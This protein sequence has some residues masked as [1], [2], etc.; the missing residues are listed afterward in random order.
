LNGRCAA[1]NFV[2]ENLIVAFRSLAVLGAKA[3]NIA[4]LGKV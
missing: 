4:R 1:I 2:T 3:D